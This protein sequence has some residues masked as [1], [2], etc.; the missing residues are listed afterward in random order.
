MSG[1]NLLK[2]MVV[3][4]LLLPLLMACE[5]ARPRADAAPSGTLRW[6]LEGVTDLPDLDPAK[7]SN[8][9]AISVINLVFAGLV[10]LDGDLRVQPD[11]A[12]SWQVSSD[13]TTYT[14][15]LR[16]TLK[17][18]NGDP[19]TAHDFV[20]AINRAL[21]PDTASY[22]APGQLSRIVGATD[23]I[24]GKAK[25]ASGV[26]ALNDYTL[27]IELEQPQAHFLS[28]L[29]YPYTFVVPQQLIEE[30]GD[31]WTEQAYG[32][33]PFRVREWRHNEEIIL[34][35]N[36][37][38]WPGSSGVAIIRLPFYQEN[39]DAYRLY[40]E[41]A[42]DVMGSSQSG[43]PS[44]LVAEAQEL[45]GFRTSPALVV[46]FVGFNNT[47]APFDNVLV[48]RAFALSVDRRDLE[49]RVLAG[50]VVAT[51]RILPDGLAGSH[52]SVDGQ[53]FDP[54]GARSALTL[55]GYLGGQDLPPVTLT[56]G[57][58]GDN[59]LV[60][61]ALQRYWRDT[62]GVTVQLEGLDLE[63]FI[64]RLNETYRTP[65]NGLQ[66]YLSVWGADY[67][68]PQNFL[69]QQ[70][71]TGSPNNNGHWSDAE[72][73]QLVEQ[74]DRMGGQDQRD[75][76]MAI[77]NRAEQ[78]ALD[79]VGWLPLYNTRINVLVRPNI[80]GIDFTPQ[81]LVAPDWTRVRVVR[82]D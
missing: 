60:A 39:E 43:I 42:L 81:G 17:F 31:D 44:A 51:E 77:Y 27:E 57:Q 16:R 63:P 18:G 34:E 52:L 70:L 79:N 73:D 10:R 14:F 72:F 21:S 12:E 53:H 8:Q 68:D 69:S 7:P 49:Q 58:E 76:R 28:Q 2:G 23:V 4:L 26:R 19:V 30:L 35:A 33:G 1:F 65:E 29:T 25:T 74:A 54:R 40:R 56:Y 82:E 64:A 38:Y 61:Q 67:P 55:A 37:Y 78:I 22:G 75:E 15:M 59:E 50:T 13:G 3:C 36:P 5:L 41:G 6:S 32:S 45:P 80:R 11:G 9:Q 46:R 62:L 71:R 24:A 20:Y 66:I 48:R 47:L